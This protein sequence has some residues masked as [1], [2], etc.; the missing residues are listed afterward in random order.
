MTACL[1]FL[2]LWFIYSLFF[3]FLV[4]HFQISIPLQISSNISFSFSSLVH[5][6]SFT[7]YP[8]ATKR[9]EK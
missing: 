2:N 8:M 7:Y 1:L 9:G 4:P 3:V 5:I 6:S